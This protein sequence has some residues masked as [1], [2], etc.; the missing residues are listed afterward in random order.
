MENRIGPGD[1]IR[2][3]QCRHCRLVSEPVLSTVIAPVVPGHPP[4]ELH[5]TCPK[6]GETQR[7]KSGQEFG[8]LNAVVADE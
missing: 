1:T 3:I 5:H 7:L 4:E 8:I 2:V 6:C